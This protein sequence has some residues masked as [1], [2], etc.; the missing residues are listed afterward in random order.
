MTHQLNE[1]LIVLAVAFIR[2]LGLSLLLPLLK[3]GSL[4]TTLLRNGVLISLTF[5]VLPII[6][7]QHIFIHVGKDYSWL[8]LITGEVI[9]GFLIGFC[10]AVPFWAVD[11]AGFLLDTLRG[12]TMGTI[13]N[14]TMEAETS[15]F[16]LLFSQFLC[17]IF[18]ISG[19]MEFILNILYESYQYL[20]PGQDLLFGREF[21]KYIQIEWRTLYQLCISFSIPAIICMVLADL[22]LGLLNRSAQQLNVFFFSMPLKSILVLL[23]LLISFPYALHHY[24]IESDKFYIYLKNWFPAV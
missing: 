7:Q 3:T 23:M 2:P 8:G 15:L 1:W 20:P 21:L 6:Y 24:L 10:A 13:F 12:A 9:I 11:M 14:S 19:G 17:V 18:F 5:P 4:G 16:G 22:A